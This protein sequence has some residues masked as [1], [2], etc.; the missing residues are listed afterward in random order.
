MDLG[1]FGCSRVRQIA[2]Q[3][4]F[5]PIPFL[6]IVV[7]VGS[8]ID[9]LRKV[10]ALIQDPDGT[11]HDSLTVVAGQLSGEVLLAALGAQHHRQHHGIAFPLVAALPALEE[12]LAKGPL[13]IV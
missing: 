4:I 3:G 1:Q 12:E 5:R 2:I 11:R 6:V 9:E 7:L 10:L 8:E 13:E